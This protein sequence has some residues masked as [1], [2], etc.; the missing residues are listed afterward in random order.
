MR[1]L[2]VSA[3]RAIEDAVRSLPPAT[4]D[5][6]VDF[7][8]SPEDL[9][10]YLE[11]AG[12]DVIVVDLALE[13][14]KGFALLRNLRARSR[15]PLLAL[16]NRGDACEAVEAMKDGATDYLPRTA[17]AMVGLPAFA[18][19]V[20]EGHQAQRIRQEAQE[21]GRLREEFLSMVAHELRTPLT[22][23]KGFTQLMARAVARGDQPI[24][25]ARFARNL[26]LIEGQVKRLERLIADLLDSARMGRGQIW[27][28]PESIDLNQVVIGVVERF[29]AQLGDSSRHRFRLEVSGAHLVGEWDGK[30]I[31]QIL[32]NVLDNALK[33]SPDGGLIIVQVWTDDG[34]ARVSVHDEGIGIPPDQHSRL[35]Q[36]FFRARNAP[37][38]QYEG[39]GL[40][41]AISRTMTERHGGRIWIES[42]GIPG[43]GTTVHLSLPLQVNGSPKC[44]SKTE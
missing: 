34:Q 17:V 1:I 22:P 16:A 3:D 25:R 26:S 11:P 4:D 35:F 36:P 13:D 28:R 43:Q 37:S 19:G 8:R 6:V 2:F 15:L 14:R 24:D 40:G 42:N 10:A 7:V 18:R 21:L 39:L 30:R 38:L 31:D 29:H 20:V 32:T 12:I 41:L 9:P 5:L 33:Y 23:M 27:I 44:K